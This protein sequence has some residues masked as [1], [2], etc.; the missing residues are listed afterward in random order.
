MAVPAAY[1]DNELMAF[2]RSTLG[3]TAT[4]LGWTDLAPYQEPLNDTLIA[5]GVDDIADATDVQKLR[6]LARVAVWQSVVDVTAGMSDFRMGDQSVTSSQVHMQAQ[7][8]LRHATLQALP[9][10]SAYAVT[11]TAVTHANDPYR[12]IAT[13][14]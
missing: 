11:R 8:R 7:Q 6:A 13:D 9:Y 3:A 5:Y 4:V 12:T 2:M 10:T 1:N 14:S